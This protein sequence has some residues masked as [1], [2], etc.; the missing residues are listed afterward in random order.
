M[1]IYPPKRKPKKYAK[2]E[3]YHEEPMVMYDRV[4]KEP[5][6]FSL[7]KCGMNLLNKLDATCK[8]VCKRAFMATPRDK[9]Y[10]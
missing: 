9:Y 6:Y 7:F 1:K 8:R 4:V 10:T 2:N 5:R 3:A